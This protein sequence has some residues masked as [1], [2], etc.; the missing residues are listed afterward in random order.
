[1]APFFI[2][3]YQLLRG[4]SQRRLL[5]RLRR[6]VSRVGA[7]LLSRVA[8]PI[9]ALLISV[10]VVRLAS[11]E[12][13][14]AFVSV[15]IAVQLAAIVVGW[16]NREYLLRAFSRSP[17]ALAPLWR[18]CL[19]TRLLLFPIVCAPLLVSGLAP[20]QALIVA[21]WCLGLVL[22]QAYEPLVVYRRAFG[23]TAGIELATLAAF[24]VGLLLAGRALS[25]DLLLI[26]FCA[27]SMARA[28]V[29]ALRFHADLQ[30]NMP[31]QAN[32][33]DTSYFRS[34]LPFFLIG[35]SG[36]LQSRIDLYL[37]AAFL[38]HADLG[39]YQALMNFLIQLQA[40][41]AMLLIPFL[42]ALYRMPRAA[43]LRLALRLFVVGL[44]IAITALPGVQVALTL[45]YGFTPA[46]GLLLLGGLFVLPPFFYG[47]LVYL[48]FKTDRQ[49]DVV[50]ITCVGIALNTGLSL[51]LLPQLGMIGGLAAATAAQWFLLG[52]YAVRELSM[53]VRAPS[54]ERQEEH[55][56]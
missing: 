24:V 26:G 18:S 28:L 42:P 52:I 48:H 41:S 27:S 15:L 29:L 55:L 16:G 30:L 11:F 25:F 5:P 32:L 39:R 37:A 51:L 38:P 12:L 8:Q 17:A 35:L 20:H 46:P 19:A 21:G 36:L 50:R 10:L 9:A 3:Y 47:V 40:L 43:V 14:G 33:I 53:R 6:R 7:S 23:F 2:R 56:E 1:M 4:A 31:G 22:A 34:A 13:W 54:V 44:A 45:L 49:S